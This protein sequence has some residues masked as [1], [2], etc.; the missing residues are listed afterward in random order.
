MTRDEFT[1]FVSRYRKELVLLAYYRLHS[2]E[3]SEDVVQTVLASASNPTTYLRITATKA[4][5]YFRRAVKH[6]IVRMI[7]RQHKELG[8]PARMPALSLVDHHT[9]LTL[10]T[11]LAKLPPH[12]RTLVTLVYLEGVEYEEGVRLVNR[13]YHKRIPVKRAKR[14]LWE[15]LWKVRRGEV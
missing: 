1:T 4:L 6:E 9:D 14:V 15:W 12:I 2:R 7:T 8:S 13:Q 3:D 10:T 5:H 11:A